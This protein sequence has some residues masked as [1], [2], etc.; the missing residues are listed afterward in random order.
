MQACAGEKKRCGI[1]SM[2]KKKKAPLVKIC[3]NKMESPPCV[4]ELFFTNELDQFRPDQIP[5]F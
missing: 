3:L 5:G 1:C 2:E 4:E